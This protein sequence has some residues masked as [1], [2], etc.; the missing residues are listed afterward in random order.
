MHG[1][2]KTDLELGGG[3]SPSGFVKP[4][5]KRNKVLEEGKTRGV[6][7]KR[8]GLYPPGRAEGAVWGENEKT[9]CRKDEKNQALFLEKL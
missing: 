8:G 3:T 1:K 2:R 6:N 4:T 9:D 5:R 7:P